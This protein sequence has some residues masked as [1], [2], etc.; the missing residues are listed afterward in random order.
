[1]R[2][3]GSKEGK[4]CRWKRREDE[5]EREEGRERREDL[6]PYHLMT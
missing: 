4:R 6:E 1:M 5:G 3:E 2:E